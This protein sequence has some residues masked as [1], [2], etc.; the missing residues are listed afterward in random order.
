MVPVL[1]FTL[2]VVMGMGGASRL[3]AAAPSLT[4]F[5]PVGVPV[6]TTSAVSAAGKFDPWPAQVWTDTPGISFEPE[7]K[8]GQFKVTVRADV[9]L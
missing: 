9:P 4:Q 6:G 1:V 2:L 8:S 5:Y 7:N 3:F